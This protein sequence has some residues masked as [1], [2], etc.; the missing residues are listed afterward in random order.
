[1]ALTT[2]VAGNVLTA[3]Q[4]NNS[5]AAVGGWRI[6]KNETAFTAATQVVCDSV[7]S[8]SYTAYKII[9]R[10]T[11]TAGG[12]IGLRLR[13]AGVA[14]ATNYNFQLLNVDS[15]TVSG[16]RS[17]G[18][19]S[20]TVANGTTGTFFSSAEILVTGPALAEGTTFQT[21]YQYSDGA[22]TIPRMLM[23]YGNHSTG[24]AY[25]GFELNAASGNITGVYSVF[26]ISETGV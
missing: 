19:T 6:V 21:N 4:L 9:I 23:R 1:M 12:D 24:T 26:G 7:F 15:T 10:Q 17:T 16:T 20:I 2:F 11:G 25:D 14:A 18:Q 13:V 5:F 8:S 22:Y 3:A